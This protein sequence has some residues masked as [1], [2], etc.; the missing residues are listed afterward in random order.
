[1]ADLRALEAALLAGQLK[2]NERR[3][4]ESQQRVEQLERTLS[5]IEKLEELF[6]LRHD[7]RGQWKTVEPVFRK[8]I[9]CYGFGSQEAALL[10]LMRRRRGARRK[11]AEAIRVAQLRSEGNS[12][13]KVTAQM[14]KETN[15]DRTTSAYRIKV[16][17][18]R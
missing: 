11:D 6:K 2:Q 10:K 17:R 1:M 18:K 9:H 7:Y 13:T 3:L 8:L 15:T 14:N 12:W 16:Y 4:Q 5:E